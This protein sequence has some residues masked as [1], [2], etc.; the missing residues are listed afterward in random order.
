MLGN[1]D[2]PSQLSVF[3]HSGEK[4][5]KI[6][7]EFPRFFQ[8]MWEIWQQPVIGLIRPDMHYTHKSRIYYINLFKS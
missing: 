1:H 7:Q 3:T 6:G 5:G 8:E 2:E 4:I